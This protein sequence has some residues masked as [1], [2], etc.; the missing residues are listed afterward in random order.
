MRINKLP[1][2]NI[3][4]KIT[5]KE[6]ISIRNNW[7]KVGILSSLTIT[8]I[9]K[10][11]TLDLSNVFAAFDFSDLLSLFLAMFS[12]SL[13]VLFYLKATDT[14]NVFYD[15]TYRF[16]KDVS[17]ILGRLEAGFGE[18]LKHLGE[19][20]SGL[21][22]A[23]ENIPF[24]VNKAEQKIKEEQ[25]Q[26]QKVEEEKNNII[27]DLA[28]K[29]KLQEKEKEAI[30]K[31]LKEND[32]ELQT[33]KNELQYLQER[34][35]NENQTGYQ[36]QIINARILNILYPL[37]KE[38]SKKYIFNSTPDQIKRRLTN[39][40]DTISPRKK[41]ELRNLAILDEEDNLTDKGVAIV[42]EIVRKSY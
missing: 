8:F 35:D 7:L 16:T 3:S 26:V 20:Y 34:L 29:A 36:P 14:S 15:N 13:A 11:W 27:L 5:T 33:A 28:N 22:T 41:I 32:F 23:V 21:K 10:V 17:E 38:V 25:E 12:I 6:T 37:T 30:F 24:D 1:L 4:T 31:K 18:K 2:A 9:I 39:A 42:I 19:E 40:I